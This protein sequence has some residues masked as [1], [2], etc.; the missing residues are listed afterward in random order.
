MTSEGSTK[1]C[2]ECGAKIPRD[3]AFCEVCGTKLTEGATVQPSSQSTVAYEPRPTEKQTTH[4]ASKSPKTLAAVLLILIIVVPSLLW[5]NSVTRVATF[6]IQVNS[7]TSWTG[8]YGGQAGT[9]SVDGLGSQTFSVTGTIAS[10]VFQ[11]QTTYGFLEVSIL[12]NGSVV[13]HQSTT[14]AYGVVSVSAHS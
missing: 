5:I 9:T 11:K 6:T 1:F 13:A 12:L 2:R 4:P 7:D 14:A 8:S 3:S 10:A